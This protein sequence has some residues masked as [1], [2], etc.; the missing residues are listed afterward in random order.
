MEP[1]KKIALTHTNIP[2]GHD[3]LEQGSLSPEISLFSL[4]CFPHRQGLSARP[5]VSSETQ[6]QAVSVDVVL[7]LT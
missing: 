4:F 6:P 2:R 5:R 3:V 7:L 1:L